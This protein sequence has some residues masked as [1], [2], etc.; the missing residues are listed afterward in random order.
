MGQTMAP[1]APVTKT[2][3]IS[4]N[5][6]RLMTREAGALPGVDGRVSRAPRQAIQNAPIVV[7]L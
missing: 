5:S 4:V 1:E 3:P 2:I 7:R 6:L